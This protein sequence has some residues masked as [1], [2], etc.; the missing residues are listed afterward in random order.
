MNDDGY[1]AQYQTRVPK[2]QNHQLL[3]YSGVPK[4]LQ[5]YLQGDFKAW[6]MFCMEVNLS[7]SGQ[8]VGYFIFLPHQSLEIKSSIGSDSVTREYEAEGVVYFWGLEEY[9]KTF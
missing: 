3:L 9:R 2:Q 6:D 1:A 8:V 4:K 7:V 5:L